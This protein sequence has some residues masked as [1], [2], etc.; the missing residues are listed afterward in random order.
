[1][2]VPAQRFVR[3]SQADGVVTVELRNAKSLNILGSEATQELTAEFHRLARE[4]DCRVI[5][6]RGTGDKAFIGGADINE[7]A[8]LDQAAA[9]AFIARLAALCEAVR[10]CP[11][12]VIA[13]LS[14]WCLGAGLTPTRAIEDSIAQFGLAFRTG[15]PRHYLTR[16][17]ERQAARKKQPGE[18][19]PEGDEGA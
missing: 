2:T 7:M 4:D 19:G 17:T 10:A 12:P 1:M 13:R 16:F 18:P 15:E 6:L 3:R 5:V 8:R 9:E 11:A 14:G